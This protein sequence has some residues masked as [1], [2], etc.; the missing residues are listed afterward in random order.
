MLEREKAF[1]DRFMKHIRL[2]QDNMILLECNFSKIDFINI[3]Q[4]DLIKRSMEHDLDKV[5]ENL[6]ENYIS[7]K[8]YYDNANNTIDIDRIKNNILIHYGTQR[9][10]FYRNDMEPNDIDVCE[11]CCDVD[12]ISVEQ[13]EESN[14]LYFKNHMLKEYSKILPYKDQM[15]KIFHI[16][17]DKDITERNSEVSFLYDVI[18]YIR[19]VQNNRLFL[20]KNSNLLPFSIDKWE[21]L[22]KGFKIDINNL[23]KH[24]NKNFDY[25]DMYQNVKSI[26]FNVKNTLDLCEMCC[27]LD[28]GAILIDKSI[29]LNDNVSTICDLLKNKI[30]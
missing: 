3:E 9:H 8:E 10:H 12:A 17:E 30:N 4:F 7:I 27:E 22:R 24:L 11:M 29:L 15:L 16:L 6:I 13:K 5:Q 21:L 26:D 18:D 28:A 1:I 14:T 25:D 19:K 23:C 20:E 2:V